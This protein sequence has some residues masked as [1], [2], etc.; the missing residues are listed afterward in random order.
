MKVIEQWKDI[1]GFEGLYKVSSFGR[2]RSLTALRNHGGYRPRLYPGK[3]LSS[4]GK[5]YRSVNLQGQ[6]GSIQKRR[7]HVLVAEAFIPN[8]NPKKCPFVCHKDDNGQNNYKSNLY[9]GNYK[10]NHLD[11]KLGGMAAKKLTTAKVRQIR[12]LIGK[13]RYID[14]AKEFGV[15]VGTIYSIRDRRTWGHV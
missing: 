4:R 14:I 7:V 6:N 15:S 13:E 11:R 5:I 1:K 8:P 10:T 3:V 2:V 12:N 9:W